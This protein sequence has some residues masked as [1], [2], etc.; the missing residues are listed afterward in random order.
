MDRLAWLLIQNST[1]EQREMII[2]RYIKKTTDN[3]VYDDD[4]HNYKTHTIINACIKND[5]VYHL[6]TRLWQLLK[7][8][9]NLQMKIDSIA[10]DIF[11]ESTRQIPVETQKIL[12]GTMEVSFKFN[13][14]EKDRLSLVLEYLTGHHMIDCCMLGSINMSSNSQQKIVLNEWFSRQIKEIPMHTHL[15]AETMLLSILN[16]H[17]I[18]KRE[19][20]IPDS[21][22]YVSFEY[23]FEYNA[24]E[25]PNTQFFQEGRSDKQFCGDI[26]ETEALRPKIYGKTSDIR[27][28]TIYQQL[29]KLLYNEKDEVEYTYYPFRYKPSKKHKRNEK[30]KCTTKIVSMPSTNQCICIQ[31]SKNK[32]G[33]EREMRIKSK[34]NM[35]HL[36]LC[37]LIANLQTTTLSSD[38]T[39]CELV[40]GYAF[41]EDVANIKDFIENNDD[42]KD[43]EDDEN[44]QEYHKKIVNYYKGTDVLKTIS[45]FSIVCKNW[46]AAIKFTIL[47][48]F[49]KHTYDGAQNSSKPV[50]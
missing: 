31:K 49:H 43:D 21:L 6:Y 38:Y 23:D 8:I 11:R 1:A 44:D 5:N 2:L 22:S 30:Y 9:P 34:T 24:P 28:P 13:L 36:L 17:V 4:D 42:E 18:L 15:L 46:N 29:N 26:Y 35:T 27:N 40:F 12:F 32:D 39:V 7:K 10:F 14:T 45:V 50:E 3:P 48:K 16:K 20:Y 41:R 25:C 19:N 33:S 37:N 47:T